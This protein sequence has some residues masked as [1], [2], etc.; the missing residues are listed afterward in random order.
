MGDGSQDTLDTHSSASTGPVGRVRRRNTSKSS[1][2][3][4]SLGYGNP[5][6]QDAALGPL[7]AHSD[8][9]S[10][11]PGSPAASSRPSLSLSRRSIFG[12][13]R[14]LRFSEDDT[15]PASTGSP[16][17]RTSSFHWRDFGNSKED[18]IDIGRN[19]IVIHHG[20]AVT[21]SGLFWK[22]RE[23]LVLTETH[24]VRFKSQGKASEMFNSISPYPGKTGSARHAAP[25]PVEPCD[26]VTGTVDGTTERATAIP[27]ERVVAVF[28]PEEGRLAYT[29]DVHFLDEDHSASLSLQVSDADARET[30]LRLIRGAADL[31]RLADVNPISPKLAEHAARIVEKEQDY[32]PTRFR[33]YKIVKRAF[34]KASSR[35]VSDESSNKGLAT[36]CFLVIGVHKVHIIHLPRSTLRQSSNNL[37]DIGE[38]SS[39]GILNL[40]WLLVSGGDDTFTLA[41]RSPFSKPVQFQLASLAASEIALQIRQQDAYLRPLWTSKPFTFV[42]PSHVDAEESSDSQDEDLGCFDRTL[43]AFCVAYGA[44]PGTIRYTINQSVGDSPRLDLLAKDNGDNYHPLELLAILKTLRFNESFKSISFARINLGALNGIKDQD[45]KEDKYSGASFNEEMGGI[46]FDSEHIT[47]VLVHEIRAIT[48]T[49][50]RLRRLDFSYSISSPSMLNGAEYQHSRCDFIQAL[51]PLCITQSTNVDWIG[52]NGVPLSI[53]DVQLLGEILEDRSSHIRAIELNDCGLAEAHA[54]SLVNKFAIHDNTL[55]A[56]EL[57]GNGLQ[58]GP[59]MFTRQLAPLNIVRKLN[60]TNAVLNVDG[61]PLLPLSILSTWRLEE[62][63]LSGIKLDDITVQDLCG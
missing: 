15:P 58:L 36:I 55:E 43:T 17:S 18:H 59:S 54:M 14:G 46:P 13:I 34:P 52:L 21:N 35:S 49:N 8:P 10:P 31:A 26:G 50:P 1:G 22:K 32:E 11:T 41:F 48:M 40:A 23:Y 53:V 28:S 5:E 38:G 57:A 39:F 9:P 24:L 6:S 45:E 2:S 29:L 16:I 47:C 44:N 60:L 25:T 3:L 19:R 7:V 4:A 12:S 30:W 63:K 56:I 20:E 62:L 27:L 33:I 42:L 51:F 37:G 61:T